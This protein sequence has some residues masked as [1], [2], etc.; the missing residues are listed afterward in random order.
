MATWSKSRKA[1]LL[2]GIALVVLAGIF[3]A[4]SL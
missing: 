2:L 1:F 3:L 4:T